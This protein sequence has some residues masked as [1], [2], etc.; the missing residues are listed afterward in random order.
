MN[1]NFSSFTTRGSNSSS[2]ER[3]S[4][5]SASSTPPPSLPTASPI[6]GSS[7]FSPLYAPND[8]A[9]F[10]NVNPT[11]VAPLSTMP[12]AGRTIS[13]QMQSS[14][15]RLNALPT[16]ASSSGNSS[17]PNSPPSTVRSVPRVAVI[18]RP[19]HAL[20]HQKELDWRE[21]LK[22]EAAAPA[23][24]ASSSGSTGSTGSATASQRA[25]SPALPTSGSGTLSRSGRSTRVDQAVTKTPSPPS[26]PTVR[27]STLGD[28]PHRHL[29]PI[30]LMT[31][32]IVSSLTGSQCG[33]SSPLLDT[34][35]AYQRSRLVSITSVFPSSHRIH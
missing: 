25:V 24:S 29:S 4:S 5:S 14:A 28:A 13:P 26:P 2:D 6:S 31:S 20:R 9:A 35:I 30:A 3:K 18:A 19:T 15:L 34:Q 32:H 12:R 33:T 1:P 11:F 16:A 8:K 17:P 10:A 7:N 22:T 27:L 21:F 23:V